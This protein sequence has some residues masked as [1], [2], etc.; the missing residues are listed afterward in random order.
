MKAAVWEHGDMKRLGHDA[1]VLSV[2]LAGGMG[3][4]LMPLTSVRAKPAVIHGGQYM[5]LQDT[6]QYYLLLF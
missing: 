4:R 2:V 1:R 3:K 6:C 5:A